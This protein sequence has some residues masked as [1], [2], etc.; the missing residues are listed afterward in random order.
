[1]AELWESSV[2]SLP[3]LSRAKAFHASV[4]ALL[5]SGL[6]V[7]EG[8]LL[9]R[10][11]NFMSEPELVGRR[12]VR[13]DLCLS[14]LGLRDVLRED[15]GGAKFVDAPEV[16]LEDDPVL[17]IEV[18]ELF[19]PTTALSDTFLGNDDKDGLVGRDGPG[20]GMSAADIAGIDPP[21]MSPY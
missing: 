21:P 14:G 5:G 4:A 19:L 6:D 16:C 13:I 10:I 18:L 20:R 11:L 17:L 9:L 8:R 15:I 12:V 1:M 3:F 7:V 2:G